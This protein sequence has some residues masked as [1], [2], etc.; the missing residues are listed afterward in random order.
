MPWIVIFAKYFAIFAHFT[1][2]HKR[3][4]TGEW[5]WVH[6][7]EVMVYV[8]LVTDN[9]AMWVAAWLHDTVEDTWVPLWLIYLLFGRTVG[10]LVRGLTDISK[11]SDGNRAF[12]KAKDRNHYAVQSP[13]CKTVK[14]ADILSNTL[15]I[16]R[17]DP[18]FAKVFMGEKRELLPV[19]R[20][21]NPTLW[22]Q[23]KAQIDHYYQ[24]NPEPMI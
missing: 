11:P 20:E 5:Y 6:L 14:I 12:R 19:L 17:H 2:W 7:E 1:V 3:K 15:S 16:A 21:G 9:P 24:T 8:S 22:Q 23:L 4:Y 18:H 10:R 13:E